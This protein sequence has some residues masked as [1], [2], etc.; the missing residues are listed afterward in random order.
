[1]MEP[2]RPE[3]RR[4]AG[5]AATL[6]ALSTVSAIPAAATGA[7]A[8]ASAA[9]LEEIIVTARRREESLQDT[10]IAIS[11]FSAAALERQ[12]IV[13]TEDLDQIAPNLQFASYG[14]LTGNNSAAQIYIRGIGQSDGSS[15][16]DP[17]VGLYID[18][19]YMGR[20]VGGVMD[21][22]D[23]ANVQILRGPQGTLFGRNTIGGA[24][25]LTTTLPGNEFGGTA[26]VGIGDDN[27]REGFLAVDV[28]MGDTLAAR[29]S[30]GARQRD[31]YVT[32]VFDGMD[33]GDEDSYTLQSSLRWLP[34]DTVTL[35]LRGDYTKEDE[36]GSPFVFETINGRQAFPAAIS[37]GSGCPGATFPPPFVPPNVVDTRCAN[38]ATWRLGEY[39]NG[40]SAPA[41]SQLE[42]W[43]LS[44]VLN[45][46]ISDALTLKSISAYRE[47]SWSGSRDADN[48]GLLVLHTDYAS[49]G[50]QWS[51]EL[52][53]LVDAGPVK[54]VVGLFYFEESIDDFL[55]VPFAAPPPLVASGAIPGSRDYQRAFINNDNWALFTQWSYDITDALSLTAGVRY[56]EET[57][58][59]E[60]ISF[61]TTPL[62]AP[63][64]IPTTLNTPGVAGPGLN[65]IP[66]PFEN[67]YEST[68]G[69][70]SIEYRWNDAVMTY[71]S[72]SQGFKSGG[73][74]QRYNLAPPGNL[75]VAFDE[76]TAETFELGFKSE[77]GGSVRLN[78]AIFSTDYDDMQLTYRLGIVPLLFNA[79]KSS[80]EGGEIEL[81]YAPGRLII[82][83]SVGYLDN[84]FDEIAVVPG[85]SQTVG[86]N[87]R[88]PFTPEWQGSLG[89]GYDF[90]IGNATLTPRVNVSYTD[91]QYFDAANSVEV[92]QLEDVTLLNAMLTLELNAWKIR[93]GVNNVTD[94]TYRVAGNSSYSTSAG[95][96]EVIYSRPR[97]WFLSASF[98]F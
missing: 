87:N 2:N 8:G 30:A 38:D 43:G 28:P 93:G 68:T 97:N 49:D 53:A 81:T 74:N 34:T 66:E 86:P 26:R 40:G 59:I 60:I 55:Q 57:K 27:L 20:S 25:L 84:K 77:F 63:T 15:G 36:N 76:E 47:L 95:Y 61:T 42:N 9:S 80:I 94:E 23:I 7:E 1:M 18:E 72:W 82:E 91:S 52:Q 83:G 35:T 96:A 65:I 10:P 78:A 11:A 75:P 51:Q 90:E 45:W 19:V 32:R 29:I 73:F 67:K 44:A 22:R 50:D 64:V 33:L 17:G 41:E 58:G 69:S 14:P 71:F 31:G 37:R 21:F 3:S 48:T 54:G 39:T 88:L 89:I 92:A 56:T 85:T 4:Q 98:D 70:A 24:V 46:Q 6:F 79:G 5:F 13:S 12:Q 16:V 62:T